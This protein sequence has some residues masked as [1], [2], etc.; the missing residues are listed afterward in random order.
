LRQVDFPSLEA[1]IRSAI[2]Q[3]KLITPDQVRGT[4]STLKAGVLANGWPTL[5]D[6]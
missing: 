3:A 2:P 5:K 4:E 1:E 6:R